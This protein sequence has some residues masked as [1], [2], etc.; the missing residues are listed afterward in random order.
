MQEQPPHARAS[1]PT[2]SWR[3]PP[4]PT[5]ASCSS[6]TTGTSPGP[7]TTTSGSPP[8]TAWTMAGGS[9]RSRCSPMPVAP[10]L[11]ACLSPTLAPRAGRTTQVARTLRGRPARR[12]LRLWGTTRGRPPASLTS[13]RPSTSPLRRGL[14][15]R[16]VCSRRRRRRF[17]SAWTAIPGSLT[18]RMLGRCPWS[19]TSTGMLMCSV[20]RS[21]RPLTVTAVEPPTSQP[22]QR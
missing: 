15:G 11:V 19:G 8:W 18:R 9:R 14:E 3:T 5:S 7:T 17:C 13:L 10:P 20:S 4:P 22:H 16:R 12:V 6:P 21:G 2:I 1:P